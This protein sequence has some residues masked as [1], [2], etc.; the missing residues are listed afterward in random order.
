M[1]EV[2][3]MCCTDQVKSAS[4]RSEVRRLL[5]EAFAKPYVLRK[6]REC[7]REEETKNIPSR[8]RF[9]P[10][11][12]TSPIS[13]IEGYIERKAKRN[14]PASYVIFELEQLRNSGVCTDVI[15]EIIFSG[16][17]WDSRDSEYMFSPDGKHCCTQKAVDRTGL[18]E[19]RQDER[20]QAE[21]RR[22][23]GFGTAPTRSSQSGGWGNG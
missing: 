6:L 11:D 19:R 4:E 5:T 18:P 21:R 1:K 22:L 3:L 2:R 12:W 23:S 13:W 17:G 7:Y 8:P 15:A 20:R 10:I 16:P 14:F 9:V